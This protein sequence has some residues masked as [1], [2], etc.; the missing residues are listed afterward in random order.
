MI[1][2]MTYMHRVHF[3]NTHYPSLNSCLPIPFDSYFLSG[4]PSS[5]KTLIWNNLLSDPLAA[6]SP[7]SL[8][9]SSSLAD[10]TDLLLEPSSPPHPFAS[11]STFHRQSLGTHWPCQ[12]RNLVGDTQTFTSNSSSNP[13]PRLIC[14]SVED[15]M[16]CPPSLSAPI[17]WTQLRSESSLSTPHPFVSAFNFHR[18]S[19]GPAPAIKADRLWKQVH[20]LQIFTVPSLLQCQYSNFIPGSVADYQLWPVLSCCP[21]SM[22]L[23]GPR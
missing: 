19:L 1:F 14:C 9:P 5:F 11:T 23:R 3:D 2:I 18:H 10:P 6:L 8:P 12:L 21:I 16:L 15:H 22:G 13:I 20:Y 4:L 7:S 17:S